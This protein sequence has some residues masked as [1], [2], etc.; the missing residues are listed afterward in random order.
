MSQYQPPQ[1]PQGSPGPLPGQQPSPF[2]QP[3]PGQGYGQPQPPFG[4]ASF[5][6]HSQPGY[7]QPGFQP[8]PPAEPGLFDTTFAKPQTPKLAKTA[9]IAVI[10]LAGALTLTG[11]FSAISSFSNA[12][13]YGG[14]VSVLRGIAEL[15]LYPA[16]GFVVLTVGRLAIEYFVETHKARE[17]ADSSS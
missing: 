11:L 10:V 4:Q 17:K 14:A 3:Q 2:G 5:G 9:Y 16:L 7:P 12:G 13:F 15:V 1:Q 6:Q 8:Q